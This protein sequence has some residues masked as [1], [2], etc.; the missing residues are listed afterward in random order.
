M[1]TKK[2][3]FLPLLLA[4][5][6]SLVWLGPA[7]VVAE[8]GVD[9]PDEDLAVF[10]EDLHA[11]D[12]EL[13]AAHAAIL[14][15]GDVAMLAE[16]GFALLAEDDAV[17]LADFEA[18]LVRTIDISAGGTYARLL[19][20]DVSGNGR[21][22]IVT[23][24]ADYMSSDSSTGHYVQ[25]LAAFDIATGAML[26]R[27]GTPTTQFGSQGTDI[28]A[29]I[30]D[31][32]GDGYNEVLAVMN[33]PSQLRIFDGRTGQLKA[34]RPL[35]NANARDAIMIANLRGL[36]FPQ[37]IVLK[38]RYNQ[39]WAYAYDTWELL[40]YKSS[41]YGLGH[42]PWPYDW[43]GDGRDE[44]MAGFRLLAHDGTELWRTQGQADHVDSMWIGDMNEDG[45]VEI[46]IGG[47]TNAVVLYSKEGYEIWRT[48][49][50]RES[51]NVFMGKFRDDL[52][53]MQ[54]AG[55]DRVNRSTGPAGQDALFLIGY[56]GQLL[57]HEDRPAR[58]EY[59]CWSS[60]PEPIHDYTG[61]GLDEIL[62]WFRGCGVLPGIYDGYGERAA[63]IPIDG[64]MMRGNLCGDEREEVVV[65]VGGDKAYIY[66]L[67][68]C[69]DLDGPAPGTP[70]PQTQPR[71]QYNFSRYTAG[72][73]PIDVPPQPRV[74]TPVA[75]GTNL[76][77]GKPKTASTSRASSTITNRHAASGNDGNTA[78]YWEANATGNNQWYAVDL[79]AVYEL[80]GSEVMWQY[81][82]AYQYKVEVSDDN[83]NWTLVADKTANTSTAQS[84]SDSFEAGT[85]GRFVRITVTT[86]PPNT[87]RAGLYEFRV[88]GNAIPPTVT[89][90]GVTDGATY[91]LGSVP[92]AGCDT[93]DD[94]SG[95]A[96]PASVSVTGGNANGVG[97]F[98][99]TC[100]GAVDD[101]GNVAAP[102]S[103]TYYVIYDWSGF[104]RPVSNLPTL[105]EA[106]A[107][108]AIPVK[109]SL[110]GDQGLNIFAEGYPLSV[111]I[112]CDSTAPVDDIGETV[113]AGGSS[114]SYDASE[115]Q[116][117]YVWKT[118]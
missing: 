74:A 84:Q 14:A 113:T 96:T 5:L 64:R 15:G 52:P 92:E 44:I 37:D 99:A 46:V 86:L 21:M 73:T 45:E 9:P 10:N 89:V 3:I 101:A 81:A 69:S 66:S 78:T 7:P 4:L 91:I 35:P 76:A 22:E 79:G 59:G 48:A 95:V 77:L 56:D 40:W 2:V 107:G 110:N 36:D 32:D 116:Y 118:D 27:I 49:G 18:N 51:Q 71:V 54:V 58:G 1:C 63:T 68:T 43:D 83:T 6:G 98:I 88:F 28:P 117:V 55:L 115:D 106:R 93:Q 87:T 105:N 62:T 13:E 70:L 34:T 16:A 42:Y 61:S 41:G 53:G 82:R 38:D 60:I 57:W 29:Q 25:C 112:A 103:V 30:Y 94:W 109:F 50:I 39:Q 11:M 72:S 19:L 26:W 33:N 102:V 65:F 114:L 85:V 20:G 31:I 23:M 75:P 108:S 111:M 17:I 12:L 47:G 90:T 67:D 104:F 24:Q 100:S 80:T 8:E 97:T